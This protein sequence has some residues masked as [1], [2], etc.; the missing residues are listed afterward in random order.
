MRPSLPSVTAPTAAEN[1]S[2]DEVAVR[3]APEVAG[4]AP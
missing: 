3:I 2:G 1:G 4:G